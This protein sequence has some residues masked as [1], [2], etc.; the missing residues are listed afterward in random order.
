MSSRNI[1][2]IVQD[3]RFNLIVEPVT[4]V[5]LVKYAGASDDYNRIHYDQAYAQ[6]AGLGG[7]IAHGML[8]MGFMGRAITQWAGPEARVQHMSA[9]FTAP[10]R[11]GDSVSVECT[12][13]SKQ[14]DG[15]AIRVN[16]EIVASVGEKAVAAGEAALE[17]TTVR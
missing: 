9:R 16:C 2:D 4:T 10:V 5:Q 12:V 15:E 8:T 7:V 6:D 1:D 11:P 13:K 17:W 14:A 3:E